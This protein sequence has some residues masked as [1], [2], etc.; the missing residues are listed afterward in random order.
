VQTLAAGGGSVLRL[1]VN[2]T[3]SAIV[4]WA[5]ENEIVAD[6]GTIL[7]GFAAPVNIGPALGYKDIPRVPFCRAEQRGPG[8]ADLYTR[9]HARVEHLLGRIRGHRAGQLTE[10]SGYLWQA[11]EPQPSRLRLD[12]A[13]TI[14]LARGLTRRGMPASFSRTAPGLTERG[15][16]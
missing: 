16:Q 5:T 10:G 3:G 4:A 15:A 2:S 14:R 13:G 6:S 12:V 7:G 11:V 1:V 9:R 8:G